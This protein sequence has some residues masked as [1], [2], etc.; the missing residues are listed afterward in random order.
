[1]T[2]SPV[3]KHERTACSFAGPDQ[4]EIGIANEITD[5]F[6]NGLQQAL[7]VVPS[8]VLDPLQA[9]RRH[10]LTAGASLCTPRYLTI[11]LVFG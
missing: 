3:V 7:G 2:L 6:G 9:A 4:A 8:P 10:T 1:M 11:D 5:R